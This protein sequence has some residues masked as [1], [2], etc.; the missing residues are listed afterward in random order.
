[1]NRCVTV[2]Q[3]AKLVCQIITQYKGL[4]PQTNKQTNTATGMYEYYEVTDS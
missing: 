1:M 2:S 4:R 3:L